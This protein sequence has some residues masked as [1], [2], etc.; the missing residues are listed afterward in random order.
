M[1][2][3][4]RIYRP[5]RCWQ[6]G[7]MIYKSADV[8]YGGDYDGPYYSCPVACDPERVKEHEARKKRAEM[9]E[10]N[11]RSR[12]EADLIAEEE[13]AR[14]Y[15]ARGGCLGLLLSLLGRERK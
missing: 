6:C 8:L 2:S 4:E 5:K 1:S 10:Q 7:A 12:W 13:A 15:H 14:E 11:M 9:E 3:I